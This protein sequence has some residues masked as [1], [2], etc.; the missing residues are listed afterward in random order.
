MKSIITEELRLRKRVC[1]YAIKQGNNAE[2]TRRYR[3]SSCRQVQRWLY[4]IKVTNVQTDNG[5]EFTNFGE[6]ERTCQLYWS[7]ILYKPGFIIPAYTFIFR[8][9]LIP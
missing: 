5:R 3:I 6:K 9:K 4:R 8:Q 1:D 7:I 2:A